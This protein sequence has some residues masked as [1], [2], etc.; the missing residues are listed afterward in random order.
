MKTTRHPAS[1]SPAMTISGIV[2]PVLVG[3]LMVLR[4]ADAA[5]HV[6]AWLGLVASVGWLASTML[7][8]SSSSWGVA[9]WT[10]VAVMLIAGSLASA[11]TDVVGFVPA[12]AGIFACVAWPS[13]P[14]RRGLVAA[15][16]SLLALAIGLVASPVAGVGAAVGSLVAF[17]MV[18]LGA[19]GRR[20]F[21]AS[22]AADRSMLEE[23]AAAAAERAQM[24]ALEERARLARDLH[25]VLAHSLGA[26][27]IQL[28]AVDA[29]LEAGQAEPARDRARRA[30]T[31]AADGLE[32]ARRAVAALRE[33]DA[34]TE[35]VVRSLIETHRSLGGTL[36]ATVD[37]VP[38]TRPETVDAVR[39]AT[40]E[41]LTNARRHAPGED[42]HLELTG[43]PEV[44]LVVS[45]PHAVHAGGDAGGGGRGLTGLRERVSAAGG[46]ATVDAGDPFTVTV[47]LPA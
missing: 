47:R 16:A 36:T 38:S 1:I 32:E 17:G 37:G 34:T 15:G 12:I 27:V 45:T 46:E 23:R 30:R 41:L 33:P 31:L 44:T 19:L 20:Q 7:R 35:S 21:R 13:I 18:L 6:G 28:D 25:D 11:S 24:A 14:L 26:L 5:G 4:L 2:A 9:R 39:R 40:Q 22:E 42:V 3:V 29:E 10:T 8:T 43:A